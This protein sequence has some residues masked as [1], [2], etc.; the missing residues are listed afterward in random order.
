MGYSYALEIG[1]DE[2]TELGSSVLYYEGYNDDKLDSAL[3]EVSLG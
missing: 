2:G 1:L 3:D